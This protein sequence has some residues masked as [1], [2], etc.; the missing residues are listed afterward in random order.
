VRVIPH[1][2][3]F[4]DHRRLSEL[5]CCLC[6]LCEYCDPFERYNDTTKSFDDIDYDYTT[7]LIYEIEMSHT[8]NA[9]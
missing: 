1:K 3:T 7:I 8:Y 4:E 9:N 5:C 2:T 6:Y